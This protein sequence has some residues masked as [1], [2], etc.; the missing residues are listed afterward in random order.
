MDLRPLTIAVPLK[1]DPPMN[2]NVCW[3]CINSRGW[4][5][6][7]H[8]NGSIF[9]ERKEANAAFYGQFVSAEDIVVGKVPEESP[10]RMWPVGADNLFLASKL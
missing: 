7:F 1:S 6:G 5:L 2:N 9:T 4:F 10:D 3:S 8:P